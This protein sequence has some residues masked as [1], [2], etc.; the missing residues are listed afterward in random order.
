MIIKLE[1]CNAY[2]KVKLQKRLILFSV[3]LIKSFT[4]HLLRIIN[5]IFMEQ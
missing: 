5:Y 1:Y 4:K 2:L 3:K